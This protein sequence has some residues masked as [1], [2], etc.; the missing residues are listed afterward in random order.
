VI[1][2]PRIVDPLLQSG[3]ALPHARKMIKN[4][5]KIWKLSHCIEELE[6]ELINLVE[7]ACRAT[8][9]LGRVARLSLTAAEDK[10]QVEAILKSLEKFRT[11]SFNPMQ[12]KLT[13]FGLKA[14]SQNQCPAIVEFTQEILEETIQYGKKISNRLRQ[15]SATL[16][17]PARSAEGPSPS[18]RATSLG[19][20]RLE[21]DDLSLR[22]EGLMKYS[23]TYPLETVQL[24]SL[25]NNCFDDEDFSHLIGYLETMKECMSIDLSGNRITEKA[26]FKLFEEL[27]ETPSRSITIY[28]KNNQIIVS[29]ELGEKA[30]VFPSLRLVF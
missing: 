16:S 17:W 28:L 11:K 9:S 21:L 5:D 20:L 13:G 12:I 22:V 30:S 27:K 10:A 2:K 3:Y 26:V 1:P 8:Q 25:R 4:V 14:I 29:P 6:E 7:K 19:F 15:P 23:R 24:L 18:L